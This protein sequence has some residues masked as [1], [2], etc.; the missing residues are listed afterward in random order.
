[1]Q[2]VEAQMIDLI[3]GVLGAIPF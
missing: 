1:M 2:I 3:Q